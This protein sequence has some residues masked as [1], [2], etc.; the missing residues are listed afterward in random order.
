ME[1][2]TN[3][4]F[5][6]VNQKI[7]EHSTLRRDFSD[8]R[9]EIGNLQSIIDME[10]MERLDN[11]ETSMYETKSGVNYLME[12]VDVN[13]LK[14]LVENSQEMFG[15][16]NGLKESTKNLEKCLEEHKAKMDDSIICLD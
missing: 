9:K 7:E 6:N 12:N 10:V 13:N 4:R 3:S 16:I 15:E 14:S 8:I 1:V 11:I 5:N 2:A